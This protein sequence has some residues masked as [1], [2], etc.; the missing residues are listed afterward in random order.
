MSTSSTSRR[1]TI[2]ANNGW[3]QWVL[4]AVLVLNL[5]DA[6][7]TLIAVKAGIAAEANPL[8]ELLLS[9]SPV[10]FMVTKLA[11]VSLGVWVLWRFRDRRTAVLGSLGALSVYGLILVHHINGIA[12]T[13]LLLRP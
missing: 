1:K 10:R 3:V 13:G 2:L 12:S 8:M 5:L 6:I 7:F 4:G 9:H 11:L